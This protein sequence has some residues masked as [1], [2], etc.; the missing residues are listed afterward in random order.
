[1]PRRRSERTGGRARAAGRGSPAAS[2]QAGGS[3]RDASHRLEEQER[4]CLAR[5]GAAVLGS[6]LWEPPPEERREARREG[7]GSQAAS[8]AD[9]RLGTANGV[10]VGVKAGL[11]TGWEGAIKALSKRL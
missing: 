9:T 4:G 2:K 3:E 11:Q 7:G 8:S 10:G 6:L 5:R 1:M